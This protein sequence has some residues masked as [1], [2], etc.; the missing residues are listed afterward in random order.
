MRRKATIS[1]LAIVSVSIHAPVKDATLFLA[2]DVAEWIV[3]IHAP[4]KDAT[5]EQVPKDKVTDVSIHA[6][7]KDA[8]I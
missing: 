8:T 2:R 1:T 6:P 3:S 5:D 4:V 7:V